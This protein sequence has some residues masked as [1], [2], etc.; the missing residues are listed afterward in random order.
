[1][2]LVFQYGSN[3]D[4]ARLNAP[5]RLAGDAHD[6]RRA[7]TIEEF[8]IAFDVWSQ[9]NG[10]AASNLVRVPGSGRRAWGVL[11]EIPADLIRGRR[12]DD[13]KTLTQIEGN[14]YEERPIL[15][16]NTDDEEV[17]VTT[18]LV[19][20]NEQRFGLWTSFDYIQHIVN[21]LRAHEIPEEYVQRVIDIAIQTNNRAA[22]TATEH[23]RLIERLR[24]GSHSPRS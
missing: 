3:C 2:P 10:C 24:E 19:K 5:K 15:V 8:E 16:R 12:T 18:F 1:M 14:R 9:T 6:V 20:P 23:I 22:Q 17:E 13:R 11:C 7:E 4:E 21:G